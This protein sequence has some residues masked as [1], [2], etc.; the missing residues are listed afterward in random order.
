MADLQSVA[1]VV[2]LA[3]LGVVTAVVVGWALWVLLTVVLRLV[4]DGGAPGLWAASFSDVRHAVRVM[5]WRVAGRGGRG[6]PSLD[7]TVAM[8]SDVVVVL[9]HGTAA[10][11]TCMRRWARGIAEAGVEAPILS[12]DHGMVLKTPEVHGQRIAAAM[13]AVLDKSPKARFVVV[14][15]SMG[16]VAIRCTLRDDALIRERTIGVITVATP[17]HGTAL[18]ARFPLGAAADLAWGSAFLAALPPLS[19]LTPRVRSFATDVDVIVYPPETCVA[20]EHELLAGIGHAH[21]LTSHVVAGKVAE[22]VRGVIVDAGRV[23]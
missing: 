15:H 7:P 14:A 21:L 19:A 20:G 23:P 16:G 4:V 18:A 5:G 12:P 3:L 9:L 11:G 1:S 17:H 8:G 10:D 22:A 13:R 6:A 2:G